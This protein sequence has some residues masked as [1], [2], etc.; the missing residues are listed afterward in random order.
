MKLFINSF[1]K[2]FIKPEE[3][4]DASLVLVVGAT[5]LGLNLVKNPTFLHFDGL[6]LSLTT[7]RLDYSYLKEVMDIV[8]VE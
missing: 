3:I 7:C 6:N 1:F 8:M 2:K 4:N 5:G